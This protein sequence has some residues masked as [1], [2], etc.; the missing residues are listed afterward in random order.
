MRR[1]VAMTGE[2]TL[3]GRVLAIGGLKEKTLAAHRS[4][5][6]TLI[7]PFENEKDLEEIPK[8]IRKKIKFYKVKHMDEVLA[9]AL[10]EYPVAKKQKREKEKDFLPPQEHLADSEHQT[11]A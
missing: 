7:I 3:R 4:G 11:V 6:K 10:V 2:V 1:D 5:I 9:K 8:K